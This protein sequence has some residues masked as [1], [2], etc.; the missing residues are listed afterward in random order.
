M[1]LDNAISG[2]GPDSHLHYLKKQCPHFLKWTFTFGIKFTFSTPLECLTHFTKY[3]ASGRR[4]VL[5]LQLYTTF[6][7][8][9]HTAELDLAVHLPSN[10]FQLNTFITGFLKFVPYDYLG[11]T[12]FI[13][14]IRHKV[15]IILTQ[16][17]E[18]LHF[19]C[20]RHS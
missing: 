18:P 6:Q 3:E 20:E 5:G 19:R 10:Y 1:V 8:R 2:T 14:T 11:S 16:T 15:N 17:Q 13:S 9:Q 4:M 7:I 12:V